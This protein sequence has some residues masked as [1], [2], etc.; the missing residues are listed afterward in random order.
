MATLA[1]PCHVLNARMKPQR[2]FDRD[3]VRNTGDWANVDG[4]GH[5]PMFLLVWKLQ[6]SRVLSS[7]RLVKKYCMEPLLQEIINYA[8]KHIYGAVHLEVKTFRTPLF[9]SGGKS[10]G[11]RSKVC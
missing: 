5:H 7:N 8:C 3:L 4:R 6:R 11:F 9:I 10:H 2:F 1:K